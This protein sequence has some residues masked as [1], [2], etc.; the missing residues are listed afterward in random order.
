MMMVAS[1]WSPEYELPHRLCR[2]LRFL[3]EE[4]VPSFAT[5]TFAV[6]TTD[7]DIRAGS[8]RRLEEERR[9]PG[10]EIHDGAGQDYVFR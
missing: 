7:R 4:K 9:V 1:N 6:P 10:V 3:N 8:A 5:S 2:I